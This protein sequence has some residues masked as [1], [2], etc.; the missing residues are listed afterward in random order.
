MFVLL[1]KQ[2]IFY[3]V[4][5]VG[6][7]RDEAKILNYGRI[8]GAGVPFAKQLLQSFNPTLTDAEASRLIFLRI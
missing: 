3:L 4:R 7:S 5:S 2:N 1:M 8:Y 6:V